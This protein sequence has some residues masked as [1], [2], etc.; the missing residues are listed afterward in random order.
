[1]LSGKVALLTA[2]GSGIGRAVGLLMG[3]Q[4]ARVVVTDIDL[5]AAE[6]VATEI[7]A[8]GGEAIALA[9]N[10]AAEADVAGAVQAAVMRFGRL[11]I[12]HNNAAYQGADLMEKD[13]DIVSMEAEF[14]DRTM[15]INLRGSMFGCKYAIP[16]M[17]GG[18]GGA[19]IN[20]ASVNGLA[21][22]LS[23]P[24][25]GVSKAAVAMLTRNV[26]ARYGR[27]GIRCNA[28][29]P[30]LVLTP[31][32]ERF[33]PE[34]VKRLH[35]DVALVPTLCSPAGIASVVGFLASDAAVFINGHILSV[36]GGAMSQLA[37][38]G[39]FRRYLEQAART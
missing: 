17:L 34:E 19:I 18:G 38:N 12:L 13:A 32:A 14:W 21:G 33:L 35:H 23:M 11:D 39:P 30:S 15:A 6:K 2:A 8:N 20:T 16:K 31:A 25:Y 29:A 36:D 7:E 3:G 5:A 28:V 37:I 10:V 26:A 4:G 9:C 27:E 22:F 24:A 1:M